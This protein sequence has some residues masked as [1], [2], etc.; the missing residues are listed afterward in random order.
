M[1]NLI[2]EGEPACAPWMYNLK[3]T[4]DGKSSNFKRKNFNYTKIG[5]SKLTV[6]NLRIL[7]MIVFT[8]LIFLQVGILTQNR[9]QKCG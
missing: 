7:I 6:K 2:D 3:R 4:R 1:L 8:Y 9:L 5:E